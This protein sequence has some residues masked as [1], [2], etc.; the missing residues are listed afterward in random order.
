MG[1]RAPRV[2]TLASLEVSQYSNM[3]FSLTTRRGP[4][5]PWTGD[6]GEV[7]RRSGEMLLQPADT[8]YFFPTQPFLFQDGFFLEEDFSPF[9]SCCSLL[10]MGF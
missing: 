9:C 6:S 2:L 5:A 1:C 8:S 4:A 3:G 10:K 7:E